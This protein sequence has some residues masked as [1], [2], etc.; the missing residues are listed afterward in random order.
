MLFVEKLH[1][2]RRRGR[3]SMQLLNDLKKM[4]RN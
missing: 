4:S 3:K 2:S 1:I